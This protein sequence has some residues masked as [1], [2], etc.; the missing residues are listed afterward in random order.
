MGTRFRVVICGVLGAGV[1]LGFSELVQGL[2]GMVPSLPVA[3]SQ[4]VIALTPGG[5]ATVGIE[6]VGKA[7]IPILVT[8]VVAGALALGGLLALLARRYPVA[9]LVGVLTTSV[10]GLAAAYFEPV[11][12]PVQVALTVL[13]ALILGIFT[14]RMLARAAQEEQEPGIQQFAG[15]SREAHSREGA[16]V[17]RGAFLLLGG[18]AAV[19]G[20]ASAGTGRLIASSKEEAVSLE[21]VIS[22]E[23]PAPARVILPSPPTDASIDATGMPPL[24]TPNGEFYLVDTAISS[25]RIDANRWSLKVV[26]AVGNPIEL[27]YDELLSLPTREADVTLACVSNEVGGR[28]V[29][30]ARWTGVLLSD[31][32]AEAGVSPGDIDHSARQLVG[33]SVDGWEAGFKTQFALDER[34][35][36]VAFGMNGEELPA[37]HGYPARLVVPGLYGYVSATKWLTEIE[38]VSWGYDAYWIQR[39]WSKEG[40]IRTQ[41]RIDT[42]RNGTSMPAGTVRIGGVAWAPHRGIE[43]VEVSTDDGE[44][45]NDATLAAQLD[46]DAW[47]QWVHV[48]NARP[49]E[50]T[51]KVRATDGE[52]RTQTARETAP[53]PSGA[54]GYHSVRVTIT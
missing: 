39:G 3:V 53:I 1:A 33:R 30:N 6:A 35:A 2:N 51:I 49:G 31:V 48:W 43:R 28:L 25:P 54:T 38:L 10:L 15:R 19:A 42:L 26:G 14:Y 45:W 21:P 5:V 9:A 18:A 37:R 34:E 17:G 29:S 44:I 46:V 32:L 23:P 47:R 41:S 24:F 7:A 27:T 13:A 8:L 11:V 16:V 50:Y 20:L 4:R 52:G 36:L 40:P 22:T 12:G